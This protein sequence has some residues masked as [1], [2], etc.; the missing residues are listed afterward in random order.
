VADPTVPIP[1]VPI[2]VVRASWPDDDVTMPVYASIGAPTVDALTMPMPRVR[3]KA[4]YAT[5]SR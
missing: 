5:W 3:A 4:D 2:G 1:V